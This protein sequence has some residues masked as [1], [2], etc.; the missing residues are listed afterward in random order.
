MNE[1]THSNGLA[2][3]DSNEGSFSMTASQISLLKGG[4]ALRSIDKKFSAN[5]VTGTGSLSA[6]IFTS[7]GRSNSASQPALPYDSGAVNGVFGLGWQLATPSITRKNCEG[8]PQYD[9]RG[10]SSASSHLS[11]RGQAK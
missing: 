7:Q 5:P 1:K 8:P 6:P 4:G 11:Q 10:V 2:P 9:D 3:R